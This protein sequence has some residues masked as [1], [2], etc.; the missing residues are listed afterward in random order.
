MSL[1]K[2]EKL[3]MDRWRKEIKSNGGGNAMNQE[4]EK[5]CSF[6]LIN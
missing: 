2:E 1:A 3:E 5:E 6:I 4:C